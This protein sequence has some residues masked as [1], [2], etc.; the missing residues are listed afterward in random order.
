MLA[1]LP[2]DAVVVEGYLNGPILVHLIEHTIQPWIVYKLGY[3]QGVYHRNKETAYLC[4]SREK[5][6][7]GCVATEE[8]CR[9]RE[10]NFHRKEYK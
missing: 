4:W 9:N 7:G 2:P 1:D 8:D 5:V 6:C 10:Q 3:K